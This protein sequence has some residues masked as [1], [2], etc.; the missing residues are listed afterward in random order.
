MYFI[1][2]HKLYNQRRKKDMMCNMIHRN[3][4]KFVERSIVT[5]SFVMYILKTY[6]YW[7]DNLISKNY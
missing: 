4:T 1:F 3:V 6:T 7:G 2:V 5:I